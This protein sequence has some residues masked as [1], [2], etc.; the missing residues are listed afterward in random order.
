VIKK[1]KSANPLAKAPAEKAMFAPVERGVAPPPNPR[2]PRLVRDVHGNELRDLFQFF[3]D[4][5]WPPRRPA[6]V[7]IRQRRLR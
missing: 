7:P 4:L 1:N 5:P 3:P 2:R 6:R